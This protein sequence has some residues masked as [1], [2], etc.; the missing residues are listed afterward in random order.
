MWALAL[1]LMLSNLSQPLLVLVDS[2]VV[3][4]L[5]GAHELAAAAIGGNLY[6]LLAWTL[7]FLRMGTTGLVAQAH[8]AGNGGE[9]VRLLLQALLLASVL[10]VLAWGGAALVLPSVLHRVV[11]PSPQVEVLALEFLHWRLL[12]LPA[13][14]LGYVLAGWFLGQQRAGTAMLLV[15]VVNAGNALLAPLFVFAL[16][17]GLHGAA[18]AAVCA[19]WAGALLGLALAARVL[20]S[21]GTCIGVGRVF[22][23]QRWKALL[24][25]NRDLF[26]RTLALNAVF[27]S[28]TSR[29]AGLGDTVVAANALLLN[30]LLLASN[31]LDGISGT[32]QALSGTAVGAGRPGTL[33][34]LMVVAG[35]SAGLLS[36]ALCA[37]FLVAGPAF[38]DLQSDIAAVRAQAYPFVPYLALLPVCAVT[39]Y[40]YDGLFVGA[41]RTGDMRDAMLL[42][43]TGYLLLFLLLY[44][45]GN[46]GLWLAFMA[47]MAL[48]G[49][50]LWRRS[51]AIYRGG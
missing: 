45:L 30:G 15:L 40:L 34:R 27:F 1:P 33:P 18:V 11:S 32:V 4:H 26:V 3:G 49:L 28:L 22:D 38:V 12:G 25:V 47:F 37:L 43:C 23:R 41:A 19:E 50:L 31:L 2:S 17:G 39:G 21:S 36:L 24:G 20:G 16:H 14:M 8:G 9:R 5:D 10:A 7:G 42:A 44:R 13:A 46:H 29:G 35:G 51:G 6:T 48:R